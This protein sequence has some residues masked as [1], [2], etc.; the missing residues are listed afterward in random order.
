MHIEIE[1]MGKV[2]VLFLIRVILPICILVF[3]GEG[4][5]QSLNKRCHDG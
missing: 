4:I 3:F 1:I 5:K 2:A